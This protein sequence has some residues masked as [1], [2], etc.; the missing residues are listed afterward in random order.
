M[1]ISLL[2][3]K[4]GWFFGIRG[5]WVNALKVEKMNNP[6]N[7]TNIPTS[8]MPKCAWLCIVPGATNKYTS[9]K[10]PMK[11]KKVDNVTK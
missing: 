7:V 5:A 2:S 6:K 8:N 9:I 1:C 4:Y 11:I 3:S 10:C